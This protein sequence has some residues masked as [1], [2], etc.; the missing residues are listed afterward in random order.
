MKNNYCKPLT[1]QELLDLGFINVQCYNGNWIIKRLWYKNNAKD[2]IVKTIKI[3]NVSCKH[4]K[5]GNTKKY[6]K[7]NFSVNSRGRSIP[8][9]RFLYVWFIEDITEPG[10]V[11]DHIDNDPFNDDIS[12][13]QL[14]TVKENNNKRFRDNPECNVNQY[15][16]KRNTS[17]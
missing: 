16:K 15:G 12:N 11:V 9:A 17:L 10:L 2:K 4:I 1:K 6:N 13:L 3:T 5:S 8:L 14:L 7:V